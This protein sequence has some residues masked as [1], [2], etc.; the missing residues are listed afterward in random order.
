MEETIKS[1][2]AS[3]FRR[4]LSEI[5]TDASPDTIDTWDSLGHM[6]LIVALEEEFG[7]S[8]TDDEIPEMLNYD[9][10]L[11]TLRSKRSGA[12]ASSGA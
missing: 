6:R 3:V 4:D 2:M 7:V 12:P 5:G 9:L 10:V 1:I 8:F 11:A